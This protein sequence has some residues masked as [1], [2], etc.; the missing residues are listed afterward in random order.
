MITILLE[1]VLAPITK[2]SELKWKGISPATAD[3]E[4]GACVDEIRHLS[5][6]IWII[7][8]HVRDNPSDARR[9]VELIAEGR[10]IWAKLPIAEIIFAREQVFRE[11]ILLHRDRIGDYEIFPGRRLWTRPPRSA[12]CGRSS[13]QRTF[14]GAVWPTWD[15]ATPCPA[16]PLCDGSLASR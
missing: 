14:S 15:S 7:R 10:Q 12:C 5:V 16:K 13:G 11:G 6:G 3:I 8:K 2:L 9:L 4:R 1:G